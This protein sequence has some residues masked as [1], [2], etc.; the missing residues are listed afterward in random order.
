MSAM[1]V[2][3]GWYQESVI[4]HPTELAGS[5]AVEHVELSSQWPKGVS[6]SGKTC[7]GI[8]FS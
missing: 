8:K 6:S 1:V 4:V 5:R 2:C 3:I 7:S